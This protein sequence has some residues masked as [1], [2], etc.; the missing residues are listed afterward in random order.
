MMKMKIPY[1]SAN[2]IYLRLNRIRNLFLEVQ[3]SSSIDNSRQL[4]CKGHHCD[5]CGKCRDWYFT[6]N[7]SDREWLKNIQRWRYEDVKHYR[8]AYISQK[9]S[10]RT[11]ATCIFNRFINFAQG[12]FNFGHGNVIFDGSSDGFSESLNS[13]HEHTTVCLCADNVYRR[14]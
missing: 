1:S 11:E 3:N 5:Q 14:S 10:K 2:S 13:G 6:G 4:P 7:T 12:V 8:D 9:F